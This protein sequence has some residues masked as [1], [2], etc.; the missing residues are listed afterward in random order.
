LF[1]ASRA[2][3]A[4]TRASTARAE[5]TAA[6]RAKIDA[7]AGEAAAAAS[8]KS[9]E[10]KLKAAN[11]A[12]ESHRTREL[13]P[14][15]S[16]TKPKR[17]PARRFSGSGTGTADEELLSAR[18]D[19]AEARS[20]L[21]QERILRVKAVRF[22]LNFRLGNLTLTSCFFT[23]DESAALAR[24]DA[25]ELR[26]A[27]DSAEK[28]DWSAVEMALKPSP[29]PPPAVRT[30][31]GVAEGVPGRRS[32][33]KDF[34]GANTEPIYD[35]TSDFEDARS[36][37]SVHSAVP[38]R[39][40]TPRDTRGGSVSPA[41]ASPGAAEPRSMTQFYARENESLRARV[42]A[43]ETRLSDSAPKDTI[44][45]SIS[46]SDETLV[47]RLQDAERRANDAE[48]QMTGMERA[49]LN[50]LTALETSGRAAADAAA[51]E[52]TELASALEKIRAEL[53]AAV[54]AR[55][56]AEK[57]AVDARKDAAASVAA[58]RSALAST[59]ATSPPS[60]PGGDSLLSPELSERS[61]V[62]RSSRTHANSRKLQSVHQ[63]LPSAESLAASNL[64]S[65]RVRKRREAEARRL[66]QEAAA[67]A[68]E[69][70]DKKEHELAEL[71]ATVAKLRADTDQAV[72]DRSKAEAKAWE[73]RRALR[74]SEKAAKDAAGLLER[75]DK[76]LQERRT[77]EKDR[78]AGVESRAH[79]GRGR[80]PLRG[81][82]TVSSPTS[83]T[84]TPRHSTS[85]AHASPG[86]DGILSPKPHPSTVESARLE[87]EELAMRRRLREEEFGTSPSGRQS[88]T[89]DDF[90]PQTTPRRSDR[91]VR[92][93]ATP[94][95]RSLD[96]RT[97][98]RGAT[99]AQSPVTHH[100]S[101][102]VG[103]RQSPNNVAEAEAARLRAECAGL[104]SE[105]ERLAMDSS[106]WKDELALV[107]DAA[108]V[109]ATNAS[110]RE[111]RRLENALAAADERAR[112]SAAETK[113]LRETNQ[114]NVHDARVQAAETEAKILR[115]ELESLSVDL[116]NARGDA[117]AA[118]AREETLAIQL[119]R[120]R[121]ISAKFEN[122]EVEK[123]RL[124]R[125]NAKIADM[126]TQLGHM[127][128]ER[129][130]LRRALE[131]HVGALVEA[132]VDSAEHAGTV[133]E[134]RKELARVNVKYQRAAARCAKMEAMVPA[135]RGDPTSA[136]YVSA[137]VPA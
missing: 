112:L 62:S 23:Q 105:N 20:E 12:L 64:A 5:C 9:V 78:R 108:R 57:D 51:D 27:L 32:L 122:S 68:A 65:E 124:A 25:D 70:I 39:E 80:T 83:A 117:S 125:A 67:K 76:E 126:T 6:R 34:E 87:A 71:R 82:R 4:E 120:S 69:D 16:P 35:E 54:A 28:G 104:K 92:K 111:V 66:V 96:L 99:E 63:S 19:A 33:S 61:P 134:L 85:T 24:S 102:L 118:R 14:L 13:S 93:A 86:G 26:R 1:T 130:E 91:V 42:A 75:R 113:V 100:D 37:L 89:E 56:K 133:S 109:E 128:D 114:L 47:K 127:E 119:V 8:L 21:D 115:D 131:A 135:A 72:R 77:A 45:G 94:S 90:N 50:A 74:A 98:P 121:E 97:P 40:T 81:H 103:S 41:A 84:T 44:P 7:Q 43:L 132:K 48:A 46:A 30:R 31:V 129:F 52:Q 73:W 29:A 38:S 116:E 55:K 137:N 79:E 101:S 36:E 49:H 60:S 58:A 95:R 123:E 88:Q 22:F 17:S 59:D 3:L 11:S 18:N 2:K 10:A 15:V 110:A 106:R 53:V 107:A 136:E